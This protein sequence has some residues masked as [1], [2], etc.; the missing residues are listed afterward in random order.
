MPRQSTLFPEK[1]SLTLQELTLD[2]AR[3]LTDQVKSAVLSY[4][5]KI[6][7]AGSIR[8]QRP[9]VHD[10]DF[11]VVVKSEAEWL[12]ISEE[13]KRLKARFSCQGNAVIKA[14][15]PCKGGMFQIDFYRA[16]PET[17]GI[18]LLIR[19][20]S[21]EHN[22]WLAGH[23]FSKGMRLKYSQGLLKDGLAIAGQ[24]ERGVFEALLLPFPAP[25]E[26]EIIDG[27]PAWQKTRENG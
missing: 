15:L 12:K 6:E 11:V 27:K 3:C 20:G 24:D 1:E 9:A 19:T 14:L 26:R 23:A 18:H 2:Y 10:V 4:C 7:V 22:M 13:L 5:E 17:F 16:Q 8:R 25:R 21:A